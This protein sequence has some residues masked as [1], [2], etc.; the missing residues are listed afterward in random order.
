MVVRQFPLVLHVCQQLRQSDRH[1]GVVLVR[2]VE[3]I[4]QGDRS[5]ILE[6]LLLVVNA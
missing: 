1:C 3:S 6:A 5:V 4:G 2:H